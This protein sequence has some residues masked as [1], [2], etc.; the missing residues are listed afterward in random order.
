MRNSI[1]A[2]PRN[3]QNKQHRARRSRLAGACPAAL[4]IEKSSERS[5]RVVQAHLPSQKRI[6]LI[7]DYS[8]KL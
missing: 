5:A 7:N 8:R 3:S 1:Y 2:S 6:Q 4:R